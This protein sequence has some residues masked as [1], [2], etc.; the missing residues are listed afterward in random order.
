MYNISQQNRCRFFYQY[1]PHAQTKDDYR[2]AIPEESTDLE[3]PYKKID[4]VS[5]SSF[6][7]FKTKPLVFVDETKSITATHLL[8][9]QRKRSKSKETNKRIQNKL[10]SKAYRA[11]KKEKKKYIISRLSSL[12]Q[13]IN[14]L[15]KNIDDIVIEFFIRHR[16]ITEFVTLSP[17]KI[18]KNEAIKSLIQNINQYIFTFNNKISSNKS[19]E[20]ENKTYNLQEKIFNSINFFHLAFPETRLPSFEANLDINKQLIKLIQFSINLLKEVSFQ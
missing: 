18:R 16:L 1:N 6:T 17:Y 10:N 3:D 13:H 5:E 20:L 7:A 11:R 14:T 8:R 19:N 15:S 9:Q 4:R 2:F 12:T